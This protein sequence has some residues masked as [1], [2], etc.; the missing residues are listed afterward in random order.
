MLIQV[1]VGWGAYGQRQQFA[2]RA[3][4][5]G[6]EVYKQENGNW[7]PYSSGVIGAVALRVDTAQDIARLSHHYDVMIV[8][9][10]FTTSLSID[11]KGGRFKQR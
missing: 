11:T 3:N 4:A 8:T 5:E 2:D 1:H 7:V 6:F 10:D 9:S